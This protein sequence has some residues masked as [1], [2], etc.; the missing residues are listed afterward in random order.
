MMKKPLSAAA[1]THSCLCLALAGM[2]LPPACFAQID[3]TIN[4]QGAGIY[5]IDPGATVHAQNH[6][7][8]NVP[9]SFSGPSINNFLGADRFYSAGYTGTNATMLNIEAGH[10]WSGHESL[11]HTLENT[12]PGSGALNEADRHATWAGAMMG[13]RLGGASPGEYQRGIAYGA[14][15]RS[16]ALA[17]S[18]SGS[19]YSLNFSFNVETSLN[20]AASVLGQANVANSS[21]GFTDAASSVGYAVAFDAIT[22]TNSRTTWVF[23]AGNSGP[24]T[25]TVGA[26]ASGYNG[27]SV[28]ASAPGNTY[29]TV[30]SFSSRGPQ[31]YWDPLH[32]TVTGVR[33]PVDILAPGQNLTL[34]FYGG[35]TG[36]NGTSLSGSTLTAGSDL[37]STSV[38]GTSF[39][40][41][42]V[43]GGATLLNDASIALGMDP[44]SRES[45]VIKAVLMNSADKLAGWTNNSTVIAGA[46][47]TTQGV[48]FVQGTGQMNLAKA[49]DQYLGGTMDLVGSAGGVIDALG[50]DFGGFGNTPGN[51]DYTF[52][53][54]LLGGT[55]FT[56][57]L[58]WFRDRT[59]DPNT[60]A[61]ADVAFA[62]LDL[63]LWD[64]AF[65][66]LIASSESDYNSK[67]HLSLTIPSTGNY[68]IRVSRTSN[69]FGTL[70]GLDYGLAWA[71][72]PVPE[73][74]PYMLL[75]T[76]AGAGAVFFRRRNQE[77]N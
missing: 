28:G 48:D 56:A 63:Q 31:D 49:Y 42:A 69:M 9:S 16:S 18:W 75:L 23:S 6:I 76:G 61:V 24:G 59:Y 33:A 46:S 54:A 7:I 53:T 20:H 22:Q 26:P 12:N 60:L 40:A 64:A 32:G 17:T 38:A 15:L 4:A 67:E 27:I 57:T 10:V 47:V 2:L 34:A 43:A 45:R 66:T 8:T 21:W 44:N 73:P 1:R 36:G 74:S 62:N 41:P 68:G 55:D 71:A 11:G 14:T 29:D 19:A 65:S 52:T 5:T 51:N 30:A 72:T 3:Y 39:A 35:Q 37:Y 50:W 70:A 77:A 58:A 25:N 13:G